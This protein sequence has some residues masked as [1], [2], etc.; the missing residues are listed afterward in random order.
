MADKQEN[1]IPMPVIERLPKYLAYMQRLK[2]HSKARVLSR[3]IARATG[4]TGSTVR[5]DF[6]HL[7]CCGGVRHGYEIKTLEETISR[8]LGLDVDRKVVVVGSDSQ[9]DGLVL[10]GNLSGHGFVV[11]GLF[12]LDPNA[13]GEQIGE[14]TV[15]DIDML[16]A[17][18][19]KERVDIGIV[20]VKA[21]AAQGV[22]DK[23]VLSGVQGI[24]N[25]TS[26][27]V[28]VPNRVTLLGAGVATNLQILSC[29]MKTRETAG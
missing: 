7:D 18:V 16:P 4:F 20:A 15:Q 26:A 8:F 3:D 6:S 2:Q 5:Q 21:D 19:Q 12:S 29:L 1:G 13:V 22:V 10:N 24:L 28:C 17:V 14:L 9:D 25:L 27:N 23:L 11:C